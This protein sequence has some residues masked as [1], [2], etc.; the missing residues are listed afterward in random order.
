MA[1]KKK[2]NSSVFSFSLLFTIRSAVTEMNSS[3][4]F[5]TIGVT[6]T[7]NCESV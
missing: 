3:G 2:Q 5:C 6:K 7:E 1:K 4:L